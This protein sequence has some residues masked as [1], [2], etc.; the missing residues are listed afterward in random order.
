MKL[1]YF[2]LFFICLPNISFGVNDSIIRETVRVASFTPNGVDSLLF[3]TI[4]T[5][6]SNFYSFNPDGY[7]NTV[8]LGNLGLATKSILFESYNYGFIFEDKAF[9]IEHS[10]ERMIYKA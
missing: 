10:K 7:E 6:I 9:K 3:N 5:N 8:F 1:T 2:L 4:D